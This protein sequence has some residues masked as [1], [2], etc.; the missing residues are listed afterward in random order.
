MQPAVADVVQNFTLP[1]STAMAG[2]CRVGEDVVPLVRAAGARRAEVVAVRDRAD[3]GNTSRGT[4]FACEA[5]AP[6]TSASM[7]MRT[8]RIRISPGTELRDP[9]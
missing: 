7:T 2:A 4:G 3:T 5:F 6:A 9:S 1:D 8:A